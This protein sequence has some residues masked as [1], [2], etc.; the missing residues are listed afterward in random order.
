M[1]HTSSA[2]VAWLHVC[3]DV[4]ELRQ[5]DFYLRSRCWSQLSWTVKPKNGQISFNHVLAYRKDKISIKLWF[6]VKKLFFI[7]VVITTVNLYYVAEIRSFYKRNRTAYQYSQTHWKLFIRW[8]KLFK[9]FLSSTYPECRSEMW[10]NLDKRN[11]PVYNIIIVI[12][13]LI[14]VCEAS[15]R[16]MLDA[17]QFHW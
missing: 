16:P 9:Y 4:F 1:R 11:I 6:L 8:Y 15:Y 13:Q 2:G 7:V 12:S 10:K 17:Y 14:P 3:G 5:K